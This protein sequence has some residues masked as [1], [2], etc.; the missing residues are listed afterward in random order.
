MPTKIKET[1]A[2]PAVNDNSGTLPPDA[3]LLA[4]TKAFEPVVE[5]RPIGDLKASARKVRVHPDRQIQQLAASMTTFGFVVPIV[6][7]EEG[8]I[9][10]GHGRY[11]AARH[12]A[13]DTVPTVRIGHLTPERKR[14]FALADNR[15]AELSHWDEEVLK[16]ELDELFAMDL[17]FQVEVTGF[18]ILDLDR[19]DKPAK[20]AKP[21]VVPPVDLERPVISQPGDLWQLGEQRLFCG[22]ALDEASYQQLLGDERA[23]LV[24]TDPPYNVKIDG[25][26]SG[27]GAVKHDEFLMA[28]GEMTEKEFTVFLHDSLARM[29]AF[30]TD[31]AIHFV[32]M[33]WRHVGE[34]TAGATGL[35]SEQKNLI[36]WNKTNAGMGTFYR[37]KHE[38]IFAYK[39]G[40]A[41]HIN[42]FGL[43]GGGRYRTNVWD[44]PGANTFRRGRM[45][46]LFA[47]PTVKPL[48]LVVDAL[49][50]CS[51]KGGIVLD[52]FL[53]SGTTLLAAHKTG[54]RGRGIELDPRY[55][56]VGI[57]RWQALSKQQAVLV[58]TGQT[59][60]ELEKIAGMTA[61]QP[62]TEAA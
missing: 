54:R 13:L 55:A 1:T 38:L 39:V 8:T 19:L 42:N 5:M 34:L 16:I 4:A 37:S 50:D 14:A 45:N 9:L 22:S 43:G 51:S 23:Q 24:V 11:L 57:R 17:D 26:V 29:V 44:Y 3:P 56:D 27:L 12:L 2:T 25:N 61:S 52:P 30:S 35:Y 58:R 41:G 62:Q 6:V 20:E 46:D 49:K 32:F 15:L 47:H 60:D 10:A 28:S 21:E 40:K 31:G 7:D 53:G 59:F 36:V 18:D 48:A 33:D